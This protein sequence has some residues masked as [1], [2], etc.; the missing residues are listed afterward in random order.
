MLDGELDPKL[1]RRVMVHSDV[2]ASCRAFLSGIRD[3]A[4][5]HQTLAA[6]D[7]LRDGEFVADGR[8]ATPELEALREELT[9]NR[10]VLARILYELG[11]GFML[12]G[13]SPGYTKLVAS[14]PVPVP[15]MAQRGRNLVHEV[16]ELASRAGGAGGEDSDGL[17]GEWVRARELFDGSS[18]STPARNLAKGERLLRECL[19]LDPGFHQARIYLGMVHHVQERHEDA[20]DDLE[21]VL[22][23]SDDPDMRSF[24]MLNLGNVHLDLGNCAEALQLFEQL[25]DSGLVEKRPR[26]KMV[27]FNLGLVCALQRRF[28]ESRDWFGRLHAE[29]PH[30]RSMVARE[31]D[32]R[33][34]LREVLE[35]EPAEAAR[36]AK[37]FPCWFPIGAGSSSKTKAS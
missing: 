14:E 21:A 33:G 28:D 16:E 6:A 5:A 29:L 11:R 34:G 2:C 27:Y 23:D 37:K 8:A 22:A 12:M 26:F 30:K 10:E 13:L 7:V 35:S 1:V 25:V 15:D 31:L 4:R 17:A 32:L 24:A 9:K 20:I 36:F 19:L 3:Q 18:P